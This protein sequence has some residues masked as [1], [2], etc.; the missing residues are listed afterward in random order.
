VIGFSCPPLSVR[1]FREAAELVLPHFDHWEI[2][3]EADHYLPAIEAQARELLETTPLRLSV[4]A[5]YSDINLAAFEEHI[6]RQSVK[7][8]CDVIESAERLGIGPVTIHPGVVGPIQQ[9]DRDRVYKLT[10][11]GL[12]EIARQTR[13]RRLALENMPRMRATICQTA[14]DLEKM[15]D[16]LDIGI[17]LDT[18]HAN[19]TG[20]MAGLLKLGG[21]IMNM[22]VHDNMGEWDQHLALGKGTVDFTALRRLDYSGNHVIEAATADMAEAVAS[23]RFLERLL[24]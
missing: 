21:R 20:Q 7:T 10:R 15:L 12:E 2:V 8:L 1:P 14:E 3:S 17:C 18:G 22:H 16:G 24:G 11:K 4:H 9:M 23:K 13:C 6:R 5:P 19:T